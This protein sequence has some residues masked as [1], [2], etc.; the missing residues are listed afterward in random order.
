MIFF[1]IDSMCVKRQHWLNAV[2][3]RRIMAPMAL[4]HLPWIFPDL[5]GWPGWG[6]R[7]MGLRYS[8]TKVIH[9][10]WIA[11]DD[12]SIWCQWNCACISIH[13][14]IHFHA[15]LHIIINSYLTLDSRRLFI[16]HSPKFTSIWQ[17]VIG[18]MVFGIGPA[19]SANITWSPLSFMVHPQ[20]ECCP[21]SR[22]CRPYCR[23]RKHAMI[24]QMI[25]GRYIHKVLIGDICIYNKNNLAF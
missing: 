5:R 21:S 2:K 22:G 6:H 18:K 11:V 20:L 4:C 23:T 8:N 19:N 25:L 1:A 17:I 9:L 7:M 24:Y 13:I 16:F 3:I 15:R 12:Y 10:Y 14:Q